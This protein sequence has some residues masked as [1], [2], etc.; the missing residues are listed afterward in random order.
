MLHCPK[1]LRRMLCWIKD[2]ICSFVPGW[3]CN[4]LPY[5]WLF[6]LQITGKV[7]GMESLH[8]DDNGCVLTICSGPDGTI[9]TLVNIRSLNLRLRIFW[10]NRVINNDSP[11]EVFENLSQIAWSARP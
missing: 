6:S 7:V 11:K 5:S 8:D 2:F 4:N 3:Y 1:I 9:K 10:L